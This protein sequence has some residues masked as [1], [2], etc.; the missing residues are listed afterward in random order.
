MFHMTILAICSHVASIDGCGICQEILCV[1]WSVV[2]LDVRYLVGRR[3][4]DGL[5]DGILNGDVDYGGFVSF[6]IRAIIIVSIGR[7]YNYFLIS[8]PF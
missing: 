1:G 4:V 7:L 5:I 6:L 3:C 2:C 8:L